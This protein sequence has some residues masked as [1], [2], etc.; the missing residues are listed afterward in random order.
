[1]SWAVERFAARLR[2]SVISVRV[3][4]CRV[5]MRMSASGRLVQRKLPCTFLSNLE[6]FCL[7]LVM[8][9]QIVIGSGLN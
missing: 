2:V 9:A 5:L 3:A 8:E 7:R 6:S 4:A 1:M